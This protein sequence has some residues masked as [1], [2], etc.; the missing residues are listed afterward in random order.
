MYAD[1]AL[2]AERVSIIESHVNGCEECRRE[3]DETRNIGE[4]FSFLPRVD[5]PQWLKERIVAEARAPLHL[6]T[7]D[8]IWLSIREISVAFTQGFSIEVGR[9]ES[10]RRELPEWIARWVLFV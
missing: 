6:S 5:A 1:G 4:L 2:S 3:L 8:I 10:L 7:L 9:E